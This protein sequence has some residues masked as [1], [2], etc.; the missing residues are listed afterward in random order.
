MKIFGFSNKGGYSGLTVGIECDIRNGFPGFDIV[1]LPDTG[2][3]ESKER[4]RSAIRNSGFKFPQQRVLIS[5]YPAWE[6]KS[7]SLL[8][9]GIALSI[10]LASSKVN[11]KENSL[12][13]MTAGELTLGGEVVPGP[14]AL[15]AVSAAEKAGCR[16]CLVPFRTD[17]IVAQHITNLRQA[18]A[19]CM[20]AL[21]AP[22]TAM[23]PAREE[24]QP[25]FTDVFGMEEEKEALCLS[26][27]GFHSLFLFG[28]PG[29]GKTLLCSRLNLL[30]PDNDST[31]S[32]EVTRIYGCSGLS[33]PGSKPQM[34]K[35]TVDTSANQF[36]S[37]KL[38][39]EGSL[40]H[41]GVLMLDEVNKLGPKL[42]ESIKTAYDSGFSGLY[43]ARFLMSAN[44]NV[45]PCGCL[46]RPDAV[47]T[48]TLHRLE[49]YWKRPGTAFLERFDIR[50]PVK[51]FDIMSAD[52]SLAK[53]DT[54]YRDR[55]R[56]A[57]ERQKHRYREFDNVNAN[58]QVHLNP[59]AVRLIAREADMVSR[60]AGTKSTGQRNLIGT[61]TLSRTIADMEQSADVKEEHINKALELRRYGFGDYYWKEIR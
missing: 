45:C 56:E 39:G 58:G 27:A 52:P 31:T 40:A 23:L 21:E 47:C 41:G 32:D 8:D 51:S 7:G 12:S 26:A 28:P 33:V 25:V 1:G 46:G 29:V 57:S 18:Y 16:L 34:R 19:V 30:L 55:V 10:L 9:L 4:V 5:L 2:I 14:Q 53:P 54:W 44:M 17:N 11:P 15:G 37:S 60:M 38:P 35:I 6:N 24:E 49:S 13:I 61:V 43:P 22:L 42:T 59:S 20:K 50:I 48:C 36:C 3:K